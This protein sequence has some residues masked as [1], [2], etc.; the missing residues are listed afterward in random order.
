MTG[1]VLFSLIVVNLVIAACIATAIREHLRHEPW[2]RAYRRLANVG[3]IGGILF[4]LNAEFQ[5]MPL[6]VHLSLHAW[7]GETYFTLYKVGGLL[8]SVGMI[9]W[10]TSLLGRR[11]LESLG[12]KLV[13]PIVDV[14]AD[15]VSE[16]H[17]WPPA[18]TPTGKNRDTA[19][20]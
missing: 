15:V 4:A 18:P 11:Y 19:S 7:L 12:R 9:G 14:G 16:P 1:T 8:A 6:L 3:R 10:F 2:T 17:T 13:E 5:F 20:S